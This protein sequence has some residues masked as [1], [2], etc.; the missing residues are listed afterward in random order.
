VR[1]NQPIGV[2]KN[3]QRIRLSACFDYQAAF[4]Q[5]PNAD[6]SS[7]IR[8]SSD[9]LGTLVSLQPIVVSGEGQSSEDRVLDMAVDIQGKVS[10]QY[11]LPCGRAV[12]RSC[13]RAVVRPTATLQPQL[14]TPPRCRVYEI[15]HVRS[16]GGC[17]LLDNRGPVQT[18]GNP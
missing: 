11:M 8:E 2:A 13:G 14:E 12:V 18:L 1:V 17:L 3:S 6:I 15:T 9:L 7:M 5:H 4:G 16:K 10:Q